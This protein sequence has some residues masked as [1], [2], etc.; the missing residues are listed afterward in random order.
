MIL[1]LS[2]LQSIGMA[3]QL[4]KWAK[5]TKD[6]HKIRFTSLHDA[7]YS[8]DGLSHVAGNAM[9]VSFIHYNPQMTPILICTIRHTLLKEG[10]TLIADPS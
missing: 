10:G 3:Y 5:G 1:E 8:F 2:L 6:Y 7:G 4:K 9:L